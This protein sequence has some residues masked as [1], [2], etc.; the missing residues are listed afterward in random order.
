MKRLTT[1]LLSA[2][3]VSS[4]FAQNQKTNN[5]WLPVF[6]C[7]FPTKFLTFKVDSKFDYNVSSNSSLAEIGNGKTEVKQDRIAT[8]SLRFPIVNNSNFKLNGGLK[9]FDEELAFDNEGD[10]DYPFYVSLEDRNLKNIGGN[11]NGLIHLNGNRSILARSSFSLAG[12]FYRNGEDFSFSKLLKFSMAVGYGIKKNQYT[13]YA[14]GV[15]TGYTF[16]TPSVYPAFI[17]SK[18]FKNNLGIDALLPQRFRLWKRINPG[19]FVYLNSKVAG[20]SYT[21]RLN[22]SI[23]EEAESLQLRSSFVVSS[24]GFTKKLGKW[25]WMEAEAGLSN[26][27]NFNISETDFVKGSTLPKPNT[28]YLI[29]SKVNASR[30]VSFSLFLAPPDEFL[31]KFRN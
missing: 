28:D 7:S 20:N 22:N 26:N 31:N 14:F 12:D 2:F 8:I 3:I 27:L 10:I 29:K 25:I 16:G 19:T 5:N 6:D 9:Y 21:V 24:L 18:R 30:F 17:L 15:Y 11:L 4:G 13:Y 1:I 23:L